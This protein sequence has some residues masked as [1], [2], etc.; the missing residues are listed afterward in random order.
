MAPHDRVLWLTHPDQ[1]S[2]IS[3]L[4]SPILKSFHTNYKDSDDPKGLS[5]IIRLESSLTSSLRF[6]YGALFAVYQKIT[7]LS[8]K[9]DPIITA[10]LDLRVYLEH[11][12]D[13]KKVTN[14]FEADIQFVVYKD[15]GSSNNNVQKPN[16]SF[17]PIEKDEGRVFVPESPLLVSIPDEEKYNLVALGGTFDHLHS[18]HKLMLS[19]AALLSRDR[20]LCGITA[21][22]MLI[23]KNHPERLEPLDS[24]MLRVQEFFTEFKEGCVHKVEMVTLRDPYGPTIELDDLDAL[25]VSPETLPGGLKSKREKSASFNLHLFVVNS[26]RDGKGLPELDILQVDFILADSK[27]PDVKLSSTFIRSFINK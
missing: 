24:R 16:I 17:L 9:I 20:I 4:V 10:N 19:L 26:I 1:I 7:L 27:D 8:S 11:L 5:V 2:R 14:N 23:N 18:G 21:S 13:I 3:D 6:Q 12:C 15:S 22:E 25:I